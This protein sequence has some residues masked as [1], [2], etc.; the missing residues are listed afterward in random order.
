VGFRLFAFLLAAF[1][2]CVGWAASCVIWR[3]A[4]VNELVGPLEQRS[5]RNLTVIA[6][7]TGGPYEN[8]E[9]RGT[10]TGIALGEQIVLVDVGRGVTEGLRLSK[11]PVSQPSRVLL[12]SLMP[13]N[14]MG[15]DDL[16][17][18][19][20]RQDRAHPVEIIGPPGTRAF[21]SNL[22]AAYREAADALGDALALPADGRETIVVEAGEDFT[23]DWDGLS[24]R[25]AAVADGPLPALLFRFEASGKTVVVSGVG[26]GDERLETFAQGADLLVHEAVYVPPPE[27]VEDAGVVADPERLRREAAIH[28]SLL[29][30]GALAARADVAALALVKMRPPPFYDIQVTSHVAETFA[31]NVLVPEDGDEITP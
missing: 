11:I 17:F 31:G 23:A 9:R 26:W 30:I 14:T 4:E 20:W 8:P 6:V 21:V 25:A 15:L 29:D 3:A 7:G 12:T 22:E 2:L 10:T 5:Y 16:L 27:D 28:S 1:V 13:E 24:V 19:G 18:T